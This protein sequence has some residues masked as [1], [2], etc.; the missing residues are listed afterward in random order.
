VR[1][2]SYNIPCRRDGNTV[3]F[4][5]DRSRYLSVEVN[6]DRVHN[7]QLF[8][9]PVIP[10]V[11][12]GKHVIYFGPGYHVLRDSLRVGSGQTVYLAGGAY[13][14]GYISVWHA[15]DVR[16]IGTGI[17]NPER[18]QEGIM[19]RYSRNVTING[20]LTTQI[21][22]GGS[23][24]VCI[25]NAKVMSWYGWG[26][27]MNIFASRHVD[28]HH[29]F[30]RTSDDCSTVYCTRKGYHGSSRHIRISDAVYW[31]DVAHPIMIGLHGDVEK[32]E[33]ISDV[34][35]D[36]V[37]ILQHRE[38]QIDYQGCIG[39]NSGDNNLVHHITFSN[40]HIETLEEGMLFN[41]RVCYNAK[42]CH[43]PGRGI[44]DIVLRNISYTG[45][46]PNLSIIA[47][48]DESRKVRNI[49]F[50]HLVINGAVIA[51]DMAGKPKWYK[52]A[53]MAD[54]FVGEHVENLKFIR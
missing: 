20:P 23:D 52:T 48:Y 47:G 42:Y 6:G 1:P 38:R 40:F 29:V 31:A 39:L 33:E 19:V 43:A 8:A 7:L 16:I 27:G 15:H 4:S 21:P 35:Y 45:K 9:N 46:K 5:L 34:V 3:Y 51:D 37:D 32:M 54:I 13:V 24:S 30:C 12:K 50:E 17:V 14:K 11:K 18:Q 41:F 53:D 49:T 2:L 25:A 28:E 36:S 26:D 10:K 44:G 22:V